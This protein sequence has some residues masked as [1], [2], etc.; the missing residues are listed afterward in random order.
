MKRTFVVRPKSN[1]TASTT[2]SDTG[3]PVFML[4]CYIPGYE[5]MESDDF[6]CV[7]KF[8]GEP[9]DTK[10]TLNAE[11]NS[12]KGTLLP[13]DSQY[14]QHYVENYNE[15]FDDGDE[16]YQNLDTLVKDSYDMNSEYR[17]MYDEIPFV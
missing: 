13:D 8:F 17:N 6:G 7:G 9:G 12:M 15:Y 14:S 4:M 11:L 5:G 2:Y 16:V 10:E 3:A 1:I